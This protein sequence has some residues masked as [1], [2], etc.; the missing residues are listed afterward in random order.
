MK[1][2]QIRLQSQMAQT[3]INSTQGRMMIKQPEA[4]VSIQQPDADVSMSTRP[5]KLTIDQ[6]QAWEDMGLKSA[7]KS[8]EAFAQEGKQAALQAMA[9]TSRQGDQLMRIENGG[10][11]ILSQAK[12]DA[13]DQQKEFNVG[14]IPSHGAVKIDYQPSDADIQVETRQPV[15]NNQANAPEIS[16]ERG[17]VT[18]SMA[19]EADLNVDVAHLTFKNFSFETTI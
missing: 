16:H 10:D 19:S 15:I 4:T 14:W 2:P 13:Y 1:L 3:Q 18:T 6:S 11:P 9:K 17:S 7:K 8:I 5:S 12:Q